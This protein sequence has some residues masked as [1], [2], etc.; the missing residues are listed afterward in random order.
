MSRRAEADRMQAEFARLDVPLAGHI[1]GPGLL[2]GSDV[3]LAGKTA[4]VGVGAR[5]NDVGR[6]RIR[7]RSP[8][9]TAIASSR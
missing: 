6:E 4:F 5:G 2:D 1:A 9:R 8:A 7:D 3:M